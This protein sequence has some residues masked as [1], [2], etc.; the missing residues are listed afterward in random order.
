MGDVHDARWNI[1]QGGMDGGLGEGRTGQ[2][3]QA[4]LN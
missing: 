3:Q 1:G 2:G 4:K